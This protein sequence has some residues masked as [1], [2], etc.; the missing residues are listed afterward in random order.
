MTYTTLIITIIFTTTVIDHAHTL[1]HAPITAVVVAVEVVAA[2]VLEVESVVLVVAEL[3]A[4]V[5]SK[6]VVQNQRKIAMNPLKS[7]SHYRKKQQLKKPVMQKKKVQVPTEKQLR[8]T[9]A[10]VGVGV[11]AFN[12]TNIVHNKFTTVITFIICMT[13]LTM[14][15]INI[16]SIISTSMGTTQIIITPMFI[17]IILADV[18]LDVVLG[19]VLE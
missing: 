17:M 6:K 15:I 18:T 14:S 13:T 4:V 7:I 9:F 5:V 11:V 19:V 8:E 3:V 1:T 16:T 12:T 10:V 2:V